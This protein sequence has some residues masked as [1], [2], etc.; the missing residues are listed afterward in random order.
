MNCWQFKDNLQE[1]LQ[2]V[3]N[4]DDTDSAKRKGSDR[5]L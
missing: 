4:I 2:A 1:K 5:Y 3:L